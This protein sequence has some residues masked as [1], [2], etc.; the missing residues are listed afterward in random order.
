MHL[1]NQFEPT[2]EIEIAD[3]GA[4]LS[5]HDI[6]V[7]AD[8]HLGRDITANTEFPLGASDRILSRLTQLLDRFTPDKVVLAGDVL[9]AF[10]HIPSGVEETFVS[11]IEAIESIDAKPIFIEGN[12]DSFLSTLHDGPVR[13]AYRITDDI[14]ICHGHKHPVPDA[15]WY[16][17]G[18]VH[19][20]INIEGQRHPCY[21][22]T[23]IRD[24][25]PRVTVLPSFTDIAPGME[26]NG[27]IKDDL[28][29]PLIQNIDRYHPGIWDAQTEQ[30]FWFP[31]MSELRRML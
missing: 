16:I 2:A 17:C 31:P 7:C 13:D 28:P 24:A 22:H 21:L 20:A 9:H 1:D 26:I 25:E 30:S 10:D 4:Y 14:V 6:L 15:T 8:L 29:S 27:V 12:H 11:L 3:R 18:H 23:P 5:E 19:P